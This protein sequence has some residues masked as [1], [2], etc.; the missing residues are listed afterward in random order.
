MFPDVSL[1]REKRK[2]VGINQKQLSEISKIS[3]STIAK[4][5]TGNIKPSYEIVK[6]IFLA[7]EKIENK[8]IKK[9]K[10]IMTKKVISINANEKIIS[11][12]KLMKKYS[13][14]QIP[15]IDDNNRIVGTINE[16]NILSK[17]SDFNSKSLSTAIIRAYL[18]LVSKFY[19]LT[20]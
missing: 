12:S 20:F 19:P 9:C 4:I 18:N 6:N 5:E 16:S 2:K 8:N 14:S 15:V 11:A 13:I 7:L 3:Q 10:D 17:M 1:I